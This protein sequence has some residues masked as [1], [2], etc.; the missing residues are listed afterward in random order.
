ML[1]DI[2]NIFERTNPI[3]EDIIRTIQ[4]IFDNLRNLLNQREKELLDEV[5]ELYSQNF[6]GIIMREGVHIYVS[7]PGLTI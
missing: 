7:P 6:F 4:N 2:G 5:D 3:K 1:K